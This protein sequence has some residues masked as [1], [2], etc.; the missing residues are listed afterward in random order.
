MLIGL[1][2]TKAE[3]SCSELWYSRCAAVALDMHGGANPSATLRLARGSVFILS[4]EL[5]PPEERERERENCITI[6]RSAQICL[7][8]YNEH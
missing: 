8:L 5:S 2:S 6:A 3:A 1:D 7:I 4:A